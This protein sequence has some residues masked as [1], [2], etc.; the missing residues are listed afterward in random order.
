[1]TDS[2]SAIENVEYEAIYGSRFEDMQRR[3]PDLTRIKNL[4]GYAPQVS[5]DQLLRETIEHV[6]AKQER[7]VPR[8]VATPLR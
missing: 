5:L 3:V 1:M 7:P 8:E 2:R 6:R 4:V